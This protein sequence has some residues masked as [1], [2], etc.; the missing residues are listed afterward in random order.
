M[1]RHAVNWPHRADSY[2]A[3][4]VRAARSPSQAPLVASAR[5][6]R[7]A[8]RLRRLPASAGQGQQMASSGLSLPTA[9][10]P[11]ARES[12]RQAEYCGPQAGGRQGGYCDRQAEYSER[13]AECCEPRA[14]G[15]E[16]GPRAG[17]RQWSRWGRC[18]EEL[19]SAQAR[20]RPGSG[21]S[22]NRHR[23]RRRQD[24]RPGTSRDQACRN[25]ASVRPATV[26]WDDWSRILCRRTA[27]PTPDR[28]L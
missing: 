19:S 2:L 4:R 17:G 7:H 9:S 24:R 18:L 25:G 1:T 20:P 10:S 12:Q 22:R 11:A 6:V 14:G 5:P 8:V 16:A 26:R 13:Q 27:S 3:S 28:A 15:Q 23:L 21:S